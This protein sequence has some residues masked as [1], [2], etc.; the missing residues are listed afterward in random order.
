MHLG[1][2]LYKHMLNA[3]HYAF[4]RQC[5]ATHVIIHPVDYFRQAD[6]GGA[7]NR[8]NQPVNRAG[9]CWG[10]AGDPDALW[11]VEELSRI[12]AEIEAAGL[13]LYGIENFDPAHWHDI[14]LD[15][16][17]RDAQMANIQETIRRVGA[18]G[19][20]FIGYMKALIEA[21]SLS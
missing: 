14:L 13:T 8:D 19:I 21:E 9:G 12:K 4:A 5:G 17:R 10:L 7:T 15:G 20:P 16:P 18:A 3:G 1:L 11:S 6:S 2:G